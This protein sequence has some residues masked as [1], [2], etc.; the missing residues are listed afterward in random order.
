MRAFP[1]ILLAGLLVAACAT[2]P[3]PVRIVATGADQYEL[4]Y[5]LPKTPGDTDSATLL[6]R[7]AINICGGA[8]IRSEHRYIPDIGENGAARWAIICPR[9]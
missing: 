1:S 2:E 9:D 7:E 6:R 4:T 8:F 3:S 5:E